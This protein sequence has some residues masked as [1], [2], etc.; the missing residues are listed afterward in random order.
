MVIVDNRD[1]IKKALEEHQL[2]LY[3]FFDGCQVL[4]VEGFAKLSLS[5]RMDVLLIDTQSV[6]DNIKGFEACK[7]VLNTFQGAYFFHA[8]DDSKARTWVQEQAAFLP[9]ILGEI[10]LPMTEMNWTLLGN[11]LQFFWNMLQEH[12]Q[13]QKHMVE[14]SQELDQVLQTAQVEMARAKK[15]H[16][17]LIPK[18]SDEI[19]GVQFLTKYAT[20]ESGGAEF[21]DLYQTSSKAYQFLI[22]SDSYLISSSLMGLLNTHKTAE[23]DPKKFLSDA[24]ADISAVNSSKKKKAQVD[25]LVLEMDLSHLG[26][27]AYGTSGAQVH[28]Q[29]KGKVTLSADSDYKLSKGE[30]LIVFSP[31][32]LFNWKER[33]H[34]QDVH[35]FVG[36]HASMGRQELMTELFFQ[37]RQEKDS[38]FLRRDATVVMMEVNRHGMHQ[39]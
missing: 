31:G 38:Q 20:G 14:F 28:S 17:S 33:T 18:R 16:E 5:R 12:R 37:L 7:P 21:S 4:S 3:D 8:A 2:N 25:I 19:K 24:Q 32:F 23:F 6:L 27:R 10:T 26:L 29:Q 36:S 9:K 11:Q 13:L 39:V 1:F 15:I 22:S 35:A 30:K 34:S